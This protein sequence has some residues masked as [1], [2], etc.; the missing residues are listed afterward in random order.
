MRYLM[1]A[2]L[3][4]ARRGHAHPALAFDERRRG[5]FVK[6]GEQRSGR[7]RAEARRRGT[8]GEGGRS[9]SIK[10]RSYPAPRMAP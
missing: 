1:G 5:V 8:V 9:N 7:R 2:L 6:G 4:S 10:S 3:A